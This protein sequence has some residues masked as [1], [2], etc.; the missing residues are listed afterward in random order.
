MQ[1]I[2]APANCR[3]KDC[4]SMSFTFFHSKAEANRWAVLLLLQERG[5][6][7]NLRRQ[8]PILLNTCGPDGLAVTIGK[9][10]ADFTYDRDEQYFIEDTKGLMTDL[11]SWKIRHVKAQYGIDV[12]LTK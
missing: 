7:S 10:I 3:T 11:A 8:V 6:L 2:K 1:Y 12:L 9:Y 5:N 4:G